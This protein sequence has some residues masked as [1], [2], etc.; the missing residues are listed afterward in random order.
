[1]SKIAVIWYWPRA[2]EI[3]SDWRDGIKAAVELIGKEHQVEWFLD[4]QVP[5]TDDYDA[6]IFW[7]DSNSSFFPQLL[8]YPKAKK[9]IFLTSDNGLNIGNLKQLDIVFCESK[10]VLTVVLTGGAKGVLGFGTDDKFFTPDLSVKKDIEYFFPGTL[11]PWKNQSSIAYLGDKLLICGTIQPDGY[12]EL[13]ACEKAGVQIKIGYF[14][15]EEI[16]NF[17]RRAKRVIIP[18]L[19]GSERTWLEAASCDILPEVTNQSNIRLQ[20]YGRE[21]HLSQAKSPRQFILRNYSAKHY[22][23]Q[24][25]KGLKI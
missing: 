15:V 1:M 23:N 19:H 6:L 21:Y 20:S 22:A 7:D 4:K 10:P 11:S 12:Q 14:P 16:R 8:N 3:F 18:S 2:S 5:Q 9:G 13:E 24:I 17:Y 25:L